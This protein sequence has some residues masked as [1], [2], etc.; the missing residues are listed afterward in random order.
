MKLFFIGLSSF[1]MLGLLPLSAAT[2]KKTFVIGQKAPPLTELLWL[3][4]DAPD[5]NN[6]SKLYLFDLWATWCGP[7]IASIP[8]LNELQQTF[9][10]KG[11]QV[12]G[13]NVWEYNKERVE[14]F[15]KEYK[16]HPNYPIAFSKNKGSFFEKNWLDCTGL[17]GIPQAILVKGGTIILIDHP[18]NITPERIKEALSPSFKLDTFTQQNSNYKKARQRVRSLIEANQW[19]QVEQAYQALPDS[20]EKLHNIAFAQAK[21]GQY[22][23]LAT[24]LAHKDIIPE[25]RGIILME[26]AK[27]NPTNQAL[28]DFAPIALR[29]WDNDIAKG[30]PAPGFQPKEFNPLVRARYAFLAHGDKES[31]K[32]AIDKFL[33]WQLDYLKAVKAPQARVAQSKARWQHVADALN[34]G[35]FPMLVQRIR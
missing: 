17:K 9:G 14:Q 20:D 5:L 21:L 19:E 11:L 8:H 30:H 4:G 7:C 6:A 24:T 26:I 32:S 25:R 15:L 16:H 18:A 22:N 34:T 35:D 23:K 3:Q 28:R 12:I 27:F 29:F 31:A 10:S 1:V 33:H 13:V 2:D